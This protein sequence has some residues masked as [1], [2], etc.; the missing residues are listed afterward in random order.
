MLLALLYKRWDSQIRMAASAAIKGP[1]CTWSLLFMSASILV[2]QAV[3]PAASVETL[4]WDDIANQEQGGAEMSAQRTLSLNCIGTRSE[5]K[6]SG[7]ADG[8]NKDDP[9]V[10]PLPGD[11][12]R[13]DIDV[14][15]YSEFDPDLFMHDY[16]AKRPVIYSRAFI[17]P[18]SVKASMKLMFEDQLSRGNIYAGNSIA[19]AKRGPEYSGKKVSPEV[20]AADIFHALEAQKKDFT[21]VARP[22][23]LPYRVEQLLNRLEAIYTDHVTDP[24]KAHQYDYE[25]KPE[26]ENDVSRAN[27]SPESLLARHALVASA[28][29]AGVLL[30]RDTDT[31]YVHGSG[32]S[33]PTGRE[34][35]GYVRWFLYHSRSLPPFFHVPRVPI[36][37]WET[38][39]VYPN[40]AEHYSGDLPIECATS[41]GDIIYIPEGWWQSFLGKIGP[42]YMARSKIHAGRL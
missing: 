28:K 26:G 22:G 3:S 8:D 2:L 42:S 31:W 40:L 17:K 27:A 18:P 32:S 24:G 39:E 1:R 23:I 14:I 38:I 7:F 21:V 33:E 30:H 12:T 37:Q 15:P 19:W 10:R 29:D 11:G 20:P 9:S 41:P 36:L 6:C 4:L 35:Q 13:C 25:I 34:T 16:H 5:R